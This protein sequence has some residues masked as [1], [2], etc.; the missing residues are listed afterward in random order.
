MKI[1]K[2]L[3]VALLSLCT[4][5]LYAG[6]GTNP[7]EDGGGS[8]YTLKLSPLDGNDIY[9]L[10]VA[11]ENTLWQGEVE[12]HPGQFQCE[13]LK[14]GL[15]FCGTLSTNREEFRG[16]IRSGIFHYQVVLRETETGD[17]RGQWDRLVN[18]DS[19]SNPPKKS[20]AVFASYEY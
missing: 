9:E 7:E 1:M 6:N 8:S 12:L 14:K 2:Y 20:Y 18:N 19:Y 17:L 10:T 11:H 3:L 13:E 4:T 5:L 16:V 15:A